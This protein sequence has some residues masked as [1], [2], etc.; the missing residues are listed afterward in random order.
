M[1]SQLVEFSGAL[2]PELLQR[3]YKTGSELAWSRQDA[4]KAIDGLVQ[5]EF[6][7][8]GVEVWVPTHPGPTMT[9]WSWGLDDTSVPGRPQ[10]AREFVETFKWS[11]DDTTLRAFDPYFNVTTTSDESPKQR[12]SR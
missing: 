5:A 3:A 7:I 11:P 6:V 4:I 8:V 9:G 12:S 2:S 1:I 10:S